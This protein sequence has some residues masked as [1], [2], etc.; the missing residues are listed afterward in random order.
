[1][2]RDN[3]ANSRI[4][5]ALMIGGAICLVLAIVSWRTGKPGA[6]FAFAIAGS[7]AAIVGFFYFVSETV[8]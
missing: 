1:M 6:A 2:F 4:G 3:L 7:I 5:L 8:A